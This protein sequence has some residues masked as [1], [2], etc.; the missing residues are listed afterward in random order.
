MIKEIYGKKIGM[1]Q[2]FDQEGNSVASTLIEVEPA[3]ILEKVQ[4]PG[5]DKARIGCFKLEEKKAAKL[6]K[7]IEG[8]FRKL[9]VS[10]YKVIKEVEID[11]DADFSFKVK[12]TEEAGLASE[13]TKNQEAKD[14][15]SSEVKDNA[16]P[17]EGSKQDQAVTEQEISN[18]DPREVGVEIF[19]DGEVINIQAKT[20]GRGFAG[21]MKR[22]GWSGQ[23]ASHG[24][25]TH[26]RIGSAGASAYPSKIIKGLNMPGHMGNSY[27]TIK[28]LKVLKVDK[29]N[30]LLFI[31]G[32]VPGSRGSVVKLKK[33]N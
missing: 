31:Q 2:I 7:P 23:P 11:K 32:S 16:N 4:Y 13:E 26:R 28:N 5:K 9:K 24:S 15:D 14:A 12:N 3:Y 20:K 27:R 17:Q 33:I 1:T 19:K 6:K 30:N 25:T 8:Y 18:K 22:H 29:E 21:G 10:S